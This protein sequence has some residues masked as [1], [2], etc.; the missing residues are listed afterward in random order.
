[1]KAKLALSDAVKNDD[2]G[3][4]FRV[5]PGQVSEHLRTD[6]ALNIFQR[7]LACIVLNAVRDGYDPVDMLGLARKPGRPPINMMRD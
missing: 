1:V 4:A 6:A 5:S 3:E 2:V 7:S